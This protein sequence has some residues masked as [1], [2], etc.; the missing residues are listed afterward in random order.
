MHNSPERPFPCDECAKTFPDRSGLN[1]HKKTHAPDRA[2]ACELPEC[3]KAFTDKR[4]LEV[5]LRSHSGEKP[6]ACD[7][8][9]KRFTARGNMLRHRRTHRVEAAGA[10]AAAAAVVVEDS[11]AVVEL[12]DVHDVDDA[13][14]PTE[15]V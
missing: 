8:C 12:L 4:S 14:G 6:F 13:E 3:G 11:A 9:D 10:A 7:V 1:A 2:F 15:S 5:H